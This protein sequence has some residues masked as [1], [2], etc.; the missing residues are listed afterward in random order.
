PPALHPFPT[1]RSSDLAPPR[2]L[3]L[4]AILEAPRSHEVA[5]VGGVSAAGPSARR[6]SPPCPRR[7]A[8]PRGG[9][10]PGR[11]ARRRSARARRATRSEERRVGK[12]C[13]CG[14]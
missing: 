8:R 6:G 10:R 9:P 5:T 1:R 13:S 4:F 7:C 2:L 3:P 12:E 14:G 11:G